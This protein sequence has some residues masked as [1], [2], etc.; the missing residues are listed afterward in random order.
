MAIVTGPINT[1]DGTVD[2]TGTA[3]SRR[4]RTGASVFQQLHGRLYEQA[5]RGNVYTASTASAGIAL[6]VPAVTGNHPTLWNPSGNGFNFSIV[7]LILGW[8]SGNNA[9]GTLEWCQT[10]NAGTSIVAVTGP[11]ITFTAAAVVNAAVGNTNTGTAKWAPAV[12]TFVAVPA[13]FRTTGLSLFTGVAATAVA[14]FQ[15]EAR[16][17]GDF[18]VAPGNAISLCSQA[19]TTTAVFQ[20]TVVYEEIPI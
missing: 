19:A 8:V 15:L 10:N 16:Y 18:I 13:F 2:I 4:D 5:S 3:T 14:P 17:E 6:I 11:I 7:K 9:P 20:V 12:N 1:P